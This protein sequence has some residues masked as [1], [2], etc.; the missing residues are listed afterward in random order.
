MCSGP[1]SALP[2]WPDSWRYNF[3]F[4]APQGI[5]SQEHP[6]A[7]LAGP[8]ANVRP[9]PPVVRAAAPCAPHCDSQSQPTT[10]TAK[11]IDGNA[12]S[13]TLR[14]EVATRAAALAARGCRPGLAVVLVGDN[15]ASEVYVRNKVKA[16]EDNG[17]YSSYDRY[18]AT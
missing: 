11:L 12:L 4:R 15:P 10:M 1:A 2:A 16:C 5:L 3:L 17:I 6:S 7:A 18:P 14:T 9:L 8:C 13:K